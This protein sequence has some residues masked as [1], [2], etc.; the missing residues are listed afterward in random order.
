M[1]DSFNGKKAIFIGNSFIFYG[2]CVL[3]GN[4]RED[5]RG[6]FYALCRERALGLSV[7]DATWGGRILA[8]FTPAGDEEGRSTAGIDLLGEYDLSSY[9]YVFISEAGRN[10]KN[11]ISDLENIKIRFTH[12]NVKFFYLI[13]NYTMSC[14]HN[15]ITDACPTLRAD[16]VTIIPWGA[17]VYDIWRGERVLDGAVCEYNKNSFIVNQSSSDGYHPNP[18]SG[19]IAAQMCLCAITGESAVGTDTSFCST[20][21]DL[22]AYA[23]RHYTYESATTN[24]I[25][26]L[27]SKSDMLAIQACIDEYLS[28]WNS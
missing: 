2:G 6:L 11:F 28:S 17:L 23:A 22:E 9:E 1:K 13:H 14:N 5:D 21:M 26:I 7:T 24:Y 16:G 4:Q 3:N 12:P 18:L 27:Q 25:D 8:N 10:N 20:V 15:N 19:Y